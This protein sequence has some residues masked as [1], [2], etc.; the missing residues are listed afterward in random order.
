MPRAFSVSA[1][2]IVPAYLRNHYHL[3]SLHL[4]TILIRR[5]IKHSKG[6]ISGA[7]DDRRSR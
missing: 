5:S 1:D 2:L 4:I 6:Y 3:S 7:Q